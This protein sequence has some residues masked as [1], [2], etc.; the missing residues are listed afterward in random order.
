[1]SVIQG[2]DR[3]RTLQRFLLSYF[4]SLKEKDRRQIADLWL[5][6][7]HTEI[8]WEPGLLNLQSCV[9]SPMDS[10]ST[11]MIKSHKLF[12]TTMWGC[13]AHLC[14]LSIA[15]WQDA[16]EMSFHNNYYL[17]DFAGQKSKQS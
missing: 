16:P 8:K 15:A 4:F 3:I 7:M 1:M 11:S 9:Q 10:L 17:I 5:S 12:S 13:F 14:E 2:K 6:F